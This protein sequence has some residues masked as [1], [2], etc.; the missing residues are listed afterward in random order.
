MVWCS[1][2]R[3]LASWLATGSWIRVSRLPPIRRR[4][5][6]RQGDEEEAGKSMKYL[7]M[8]VHNTGGSGSDA[9]IHIIDH[10]NYILC[11]STST[12]RCAMVNRVRITTE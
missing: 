4:G 12:G 5:H 7:Y 1:G 11:T 2:W 9:T 6:G 3:C 8:Y 10:D